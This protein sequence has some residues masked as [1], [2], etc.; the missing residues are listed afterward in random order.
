MIEI[1]LVKSNITVKIFCNP[2]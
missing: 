1:V 2:K